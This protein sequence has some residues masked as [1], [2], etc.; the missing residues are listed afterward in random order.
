MKKFLIGI[1]LV[2]TA[3]V[4]VLG[5]YLNTIVKNSVEGVGSFVTGVPIKLK[6]VNISLLSGKG[7]LKG[8]FVGNPKGFK[9]ASAFKLKEV[10]IVL[11]VHSILSDKIIVK[12]ILVNAPHV[13]YEKSGR[14]DNINEILKNV[15]E[16]AGGVRRVIPQNGGEK[17]D[18]EITFPM[19]DIH[20]KDIGKTKEGA[21]MSNALQEIFQVLSDNVI[22]AVAG[23]TVG[24]LNGL[25][26]K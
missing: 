19:E 22:T 9:T 1:P 13:T 20:M 17:K 11:D 5:L 25:F 15:E 21:S 12:E 6:D 2:L 8:I 7:Q 23:S 4:L 3:L 24:K 16:L 10:R 14:S 26:G 18:R